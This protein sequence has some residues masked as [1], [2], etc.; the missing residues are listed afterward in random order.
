MKGAQGIIKTALWYHDAIESWSPFH[1]VT[2]CVKVYE[3]SVPKILLLQRGHWRASS[4]ALPPMPV[5]MRC[6]T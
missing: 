6:S 1:C 4:P 2:A 5:S 3:K